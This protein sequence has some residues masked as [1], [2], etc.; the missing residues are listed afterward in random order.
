MDE[1]KKDYKGFEEGKYPEPTARKRPK[2][3]PAVDELFTYGVDIPIPITMGQLRCAYNES[4]EDP[5]ILELLDGYKVPPLG[6]TKVGVHGSGHARG[7]IY[8]PGIFRLN[9][10]TVGLAKG[11]TQSEMVIAKAE[12]KVNKIMAGVQRSLEK[13]DYI[14]KMGGA[15]AD[16]DTLDVV[17]EIVMDKII[18]EDSAREARQFLGDLNKLVDN[19]GAIIDDRNS[20]AR[21]M[22]EM[23]KP[24]LDAILEYTENVIRL[25]QQAQQNPVIEYDGEF[26]DVTG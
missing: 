4:D 5:L 9:E 14:I 21:E 1:K 23:G 8:P 10:H 25:A 7:F 19:Q 6:I 24:Q 15:D 2:D 20:M 22:A 13:H 12:K 16:L 17:A 11:A 3:F 26:E 18:T